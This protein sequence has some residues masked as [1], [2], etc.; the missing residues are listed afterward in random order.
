VSVAVPARTR[1]RSARPAPDRARRAPARPAP[2]P[3]RLTAAGLVWMAV[4]AALLGGIVFLNVAALRVSIRV[5]GLAAHAQS[6]QQANRTLNAEVAS[7]TVPYR[8]DAKAKAYGMVQLSPTAHSYVSY[9]RH[10][11]DHRARAFA[12]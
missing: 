3:R 10:R 8:I 2:A 5:S 4:L 6:L 7:L 11:H 9:T 12:R 1:A